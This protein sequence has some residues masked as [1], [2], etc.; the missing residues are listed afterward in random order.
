MIDCSSS[1]QSVMGNDSIW[2]AMGEWSSRAF[3]AG[4]PVSVRTRMLAVEVLRRQLFQWRGGGKRVLVGFDF[5]FGYPAGFAAALG[6]TTS[7]G[8]CGALHSHFAAHV[9]DSPNNAHNRD[10]FAE[11]CT[12]RWELRVHSRAV[13]SL[14]PLPR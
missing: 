14:L 13:Q 9:M 3:D 6:L 8:A 12:G 2:I 5:A 10:A 7:D 4:P 11:E 1:S